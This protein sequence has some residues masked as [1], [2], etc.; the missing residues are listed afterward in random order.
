M[1]LLNFL[2]ILAFSWVWYDYRKQKGDTMG[3]AGSGY[4]WLGCLAF[5]VVLNAAEY[6]LGL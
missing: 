2:L 5:G 1:I 6:L 4:Y 3:I